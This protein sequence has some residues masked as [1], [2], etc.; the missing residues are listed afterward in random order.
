MPLFIKKLYFILPAEDLFRV[1]KLSIMLT[2]VA[3]MEVLGLALISFL[4]VNI[5]NLSEAIA[6]ISFMQQI[7]LFFNF[8]KDYYVLVF[9][10]FIIFYSLITLLSSILIVRSLNISG[11][12]IGSRIR[13][14]ILEYYLEMDWI[15]LSNI[16]LTEQTSKIIN[17][18]RQVGSIIIFSLHL[19]S[20]LILSL[21]IIGGLISVILIFL[22][23]FVI[24][25][26]GPTPSH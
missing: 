13:Q 14:K 19:F 26:D 20:R 23:D 15:N 3:V 2:V 17:D 4:L 16:K 1:V 7:M 21:F 9:C 11:Q 18:G 12:F 8:S 6:S 25:N 5:E 10:I 24:L 22:F